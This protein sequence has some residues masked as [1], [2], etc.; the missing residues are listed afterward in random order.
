MSFMQGSPLPDVTVTRT[1]EEE[2]PS[3]Y[4]D[5]LEKLGAAGETAL[6]IPST[7]LVAGMDP[8]QTQGYGALPT[9]AGAY[10]DL[11]GEAETAAKGFGGITSQDISAFMDPYQQSVV[12]E[13]GRLSA[14]NVQRSVLPQLKAGFVGSGGLGGQRYA[15]ALG[16]SLADIQLG[17]Q[18]QQAGLL[19]KGYQDAV[20]NAFKQAQEERQAATTQADLAELAQQLG[21]SEVGALVEGGAQ[22]QAF[23]QSQIEAPLKT[24]M[25]VAQLMRGYQIPLDTTEIEKGPKPGAYGTSTFQDIGSILGLIGAYGGKA[26]ANANPLSIAGY[27]AKEITDFLKGIDLGFGG[28]GVNPISESEL[29]AII[30]AAN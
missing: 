8:L 29:N 12:D 9:A 5:Y 3:Y 18:G 23:E 4:T 2:A 11:F 25:N 30:D 22:K 26:P 7:D 27:G 6:G 17:L 28:S 21:L 1:T 10:G 14:L 19:S 24:A 15:G 13:L 16:Q 20:A